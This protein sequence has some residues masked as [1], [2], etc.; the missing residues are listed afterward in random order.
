MVIAATWVVLAASA[1]SVGCKKSSPAPKTDASVGDAKT[2]GKDG[3]VSCAN[4]PAASKIKSSSCSCDKE[5]ASGICADGVCCATRCDG[6]CMACN[7]LTS[8]GECTKVPA[9]GKPTDPAECPVTGKSSCQQD[10]TC[11]GNGACRL[12]VK[13]TVCQAGTCDGDGVAAGRVCDGKGSCVAGRAVSCRPYGCDPATNQCATSCTTTCAT[14]VQCVGNSCGKA[15]N[16]AACQTAAD[17]ESGFCADHVCCNVACTSPCLSCNQTGFLGR[18]QLT[19]PG[20]PDDGCKAEAQTTCGL[21]GLCDSSGSCSHFPATSTLCGD[22]VCV[23]ETMLSMNRTCDG[24]GTCLDARF[25]DCSPY[26]CGAGMCGKTCN[27]DDDC[28]KDHPCVAVAGST[29]KQCSGLKKNGVA[30]GAGPECESTHCVDGVCCDTSCEGGCRSCALQGNAGTCSLVARGATDPR[31]ICTDLG[32]ASCGTNGLCDGT[33]ACD[34]Y[35][36]GST[37]GEESCTSGAYRPPATC[38]N[39]GQCVDSASRTCNPYVCA[40][41][42]CL[43]KC[44]RDIDCVAGQVCTNGSCGLKP[45]GAT[46]TTGTECLSTHCAQG[47]CCNA[48]CN[49]A[50]VACDL[51]GSMGIC[52]SVKDGSTDPQVACVASPQSSCGTTGKCVGGAC[53]KWAS[54]SKCG[55]AVCASASSVKPTAACDGNGTCV[56]PA[57]RSCGNFMCQIDACKTICT[58]DNDC[59]APTTCSNG[60]CGLKGPGAACTAANQCASGFCTEGVCCDSACSDATGTTGLCRSCKVAG[61]VGTCTPVAAGGVDPK[62]RCVASAPGSGN[63]SN[64]GTC[65]GAGACRPWSTATGCRQQ[66]CAG[67]TLTAAANCD[68]AGNCQPAMTSPCAPYVCSATSPSCLTTCSQNAD[69][70]AGQTCRKV[71]NKCGNTLANGQACGAPGDCASGNCT[72][73]VCC[74]GACGGSC[75]S[76]TLTGKVGTCSSISAGGNPRVSG[77]CPPA[78]PCGNTGQCNGVGGCAVR[79]TATSCRLQSCTGSTLTAA[80]NCD[81]AGNCQPLMTSSCAPYVCGASAC[82]IICTSSTECA[83]GVICRQVDHMCGTPLPNGQVCAASGDCMSGICS[84]EGV[85]CDGAC[86]GSCQSCKLAGKVGTCSSIAAGTAP[87]VANAC[88]PAPPCGNT[89]QCNGAGACALASTA[90]DC[91]VT[92]SCTGA[93]MTGPASKCDGAGNC[94]APAPVACMTGYICAGTACATMCSGTGVGSCAGGF[95]C[96]S[97]HCQPPAGMGSDCT[98]PTD[99]ATGL[100]C[101]S[102][103]AKTICCATS[104][105]EQACGTKALCAA[106]GSACQSH[107]GEAC[108]AA[109][110]SADLHSA[111]AAGTCSGTGTCNQPSTP[112]APGFLCAGGVCAT[113]CVDNTVCDV[114]MG[115]AC[116]L[117]SGQCEI[118]AP[119]PA[120]P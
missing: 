22:A 70:I 7:L 76:C 66:S 30:C 80:A 75:Q 60:S 98:A 72:E 25:I 44:T 13:E 63:C 86:G 50:C 79:S 81:G 2:D 31:A 116:N 62:S 95:T 99:C 77:A 4:V 41:T 15:I 97:G 3:G 10:G 59:L 55:D 48:A 40:G 67:S 118:P 115:Y 88:P 53:A 94:A 113:M 47:V 17:C 51:A 119:P 100:S 108:G 90:T 112:C 6:T 52:T 84:A 26:K 74:D 73:G 33:G 65:N 102:N 71:D 11:D 106:D 78:A 89:G 29:T 37:C 46:C 57:N 19:P 114:A 107:G 45:A 49:G 23:G 101:I 93:A 27:V 34:K 104:C 8:L 110:C 9:G 68:G 32:Q 38:N 5:C 92:M 105:A 20:L 117:T 24:Q 14:G 56:T 21:T 69:C 54:G 111:V 18:C 58:T 61:K 109:S 120:G 42:K 83:A 91:N 16:G 28:A 82:L 85:C 64:D 36:V 103:G 96:I 35:A 87:R 12:W 39:Q 43:D 1:L